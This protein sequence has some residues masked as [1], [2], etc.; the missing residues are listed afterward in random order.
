MAVLSP[1]QIAQYAA[2]AGFTGA[3]LQKITAIAM[4]E[5]GGN[6]LAY[7]PGDPHGGSF[8]ITQINGVHP[9]ASGALG[10][11]QTAMNL[12]FQVSGGGN[13]F[14]PWTTYTSGAYQ[15][16]MGQANGV[17]LTG[18]SGGVGGAGSAYFSAPSVG[19]GAG[20]PGYV[21]APGGFLSGLTAG[22]QPSLQAYSP[23][24]EGS[25]MASGLPYGGQTFSSPY[26][27]IAQSSLGDLIG[28]YGSAGVSAVPGILSGL[29][30]A[31]S[32]LGKAQQMATDALGNTSSVGS[33][34][35]AIFAAIANL[36]ERGAFIILGLV[37]LAI[38]AYAMVSPQQKAA[39]IAAIAK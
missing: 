25:G 15:K 20:A 27:A 17:D 16:F 1:S 38:A 32:G 34:L 36:S 39:A 9:G 7:N 12:A 35:S 18:A 8:G 6:T 31:Q 14:S 26:A 5:S 2:N 28:N 24:P 37:L 22:Q 10:D 4:A 19:A 30:Q 11:P 23:A 13:N 3:G 21:Q 29:G 33:P